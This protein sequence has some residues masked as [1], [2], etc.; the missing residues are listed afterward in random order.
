MIPLEV[1][2]PENT[3]WWAWVAVALIT[4]LLNYLLNRPLR[5]KVDEVA[6]DAKA[7][8]KQTEN[9]HADAE[10]PN[11]REELTAARTS[12]ESLA[13][14]VTEVKGH[15]SGLRLDH[16]AMR[17][18]VT[19]IREEMTG[20][21]DDARDDRKALA[22]Q[23]LALEDHIADMPQRTKQAITDGLREGAEAIAGAVADHERRLHPDSK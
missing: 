19:G 21:R 2:P 15:V 18:D 22:S 20:I 9:E 13:A 6:D 14:L 7:S 4:A 11:L 16:T 12:V 5:R 3:P 17:R 1:A 8:R 23:R 10:Y